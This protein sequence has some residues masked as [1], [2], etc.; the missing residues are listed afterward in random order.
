MSVLEV[1]VSVSVY[2]LIGAARVVQQTQITERWKILGG[3]IFWKYLI[4]VS[5]VVVIEPEG[6]EFGKPWKLHVRD[7]SIVVQHKLFQIFEFIYIFV[8]SRRER[9][10]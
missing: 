5:D 6:V 2:Q 7:D 1:V 9:E 3:R 4:Q 10:G 8:C